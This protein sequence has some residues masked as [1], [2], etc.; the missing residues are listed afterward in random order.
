MR[1]VT[2][3][4]ESYFAS[5]QS[6]LGEARRVPFKVVSI[7]EWQPQPSQCHK[8]VDEW[9]AGCHNCTRARGWLTW[10]KDE[11]GS[12]FFIAHSIVDDN[13]IL[14]DITP[15][16]PNTPPLMFLKHIGSTEAFD[17]MQPTWSSATYPFVF[18]LPEESGEFEE[19]A[20][21]N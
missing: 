14:Y 18:D 15:I 13:G 19:D 3:A 17:A 6:R 5:L 1:I 16:A 12:C 10:G 4:I 2:P 9:I 20:E 8:N 7:A 11:T 21:Y